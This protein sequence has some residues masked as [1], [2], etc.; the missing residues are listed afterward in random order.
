[1]KKNVIIFKFETNLNNAFTITS[2][3]PC[4][5]TRPI[6]HRTQI[7][8][9]PKPA[10]NWAR[11][12]HWDRWTKI[13][14]ELHYLKEKRS[15]QLK[16]IARIP[17]SYLQLGQTWIGSVSAGR[18]VQNEYRREIRAN[19]AE[20]LGVGSEIQGAMLAI[21]SAPQQAFVIVQLVRDGRPVNL[22]RGC[23]HHEVVPLWNLRYIYNVIKKIAKR[24]KLF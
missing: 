21:I 3:P 24:K 2:A 12:C 17:N 19:C 14:W 10:I 20:I 6:W 16:R 7:A 11:L 1:M 23:E 15:S 9:R 22:H 4:S 5:L 13:W 18:V 8:G